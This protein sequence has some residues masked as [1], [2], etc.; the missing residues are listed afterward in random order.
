V[1]RMAQASQ[2]GVESIS[3]DLRPP[4]LGRVEV[5]L[6]FR[7]N[8][9][10]VVMRAEQPETFEALRQ[11]RHNLEQQMAD[12]GLQLGAGGLD[13]Q[14]GRLSEPEPEA[15]A[16]SSAPAGAET[17]AEDMPADPR[18]PASDSLIDIIA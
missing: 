18:R 4:E 13:L 5:Q 6:T 17:A 15:V 9:V 7:D 3:V 2:D 16:R 11:E 12:A 8:T 1:L 10:Q 14:Q